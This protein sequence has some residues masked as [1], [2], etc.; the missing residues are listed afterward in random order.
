DVVAEPPGDAGLPGPG[1]PQAHVAVPTPRG[2]PL[3]I[4]AVGH[5]VDVAG[6][7]AEYRQSRLGI[8][9]PD[10]QRVVRAR[11]SNLTAIATECQP[12]HVSRM[13]VPDQ[14]FFP[15]GRFPNADGAVG[16][17]RG[18]PLPVRT[19]HRRVNLAGVTFVSRQRL[20]SGCGIPL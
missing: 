6:V 20:L 15:G 13:A 19:V 9:I 7:A 12:A 16:A 18:N 8:R 17:S 5:R 11:G 1:I 14:R 2:D 4:G 10:P 3:P